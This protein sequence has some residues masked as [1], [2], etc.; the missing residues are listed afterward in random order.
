MKSDLQIQQ[1]IMNALVRDR[2]TNAIAIS[3]TVAGGVARLDGC[4]ASVS[5]KVAAVKA[6][7]RVHGVRA[8]QFNWRLT[9]EKP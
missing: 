6:A 1:E 3:V 5:E 4:L 8:L 9:R 2:A 7:Q